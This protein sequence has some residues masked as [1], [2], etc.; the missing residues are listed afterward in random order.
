VSDKL[1]VVTDDQFDLDVMFADG[2]V[3]V[4]FWAEW[5]AP[6]RQLTPVLEQIASENEGRLKIAKLN[7]DD[8]PKITGRF[9]VMTIPTL[10]LFKDGEAQLRMVGA[11]SKSALLEALDPHIS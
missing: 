10:I 11:K 4:D 5:C 7:V 8:N 3:L 6:C 2:P 1:Q 9:E